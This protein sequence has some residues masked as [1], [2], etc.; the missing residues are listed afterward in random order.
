MKK[1]PA[2]IYFYK[3]VYNTK[4]SELYNELEEAPLTVHEY[5]FMCDVIAGL[6]NK[7]LAAKCHKSPSRI[8]QWKRELCER[9]HAFDIANA[10]R[11]SL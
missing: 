9:L 5:A 6:S 3:K 7:E 2:V 1:S 10:K 11:L 8:A 4:K